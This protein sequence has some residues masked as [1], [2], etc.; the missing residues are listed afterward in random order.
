MLFLSPILFPQLNEF[1]L[2]QAS[3]LATYLLPARIGFEESEKFRKLISC[4]IV[5]NVYVADSK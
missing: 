1:V 2:T 5:L 3:F 4:F